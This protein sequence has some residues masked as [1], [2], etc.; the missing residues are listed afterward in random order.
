TASLIL[1][2]QNVDLAGGAPLSTP[3]EAEGGCVPAGAPMLK[4][5]M[6]VKQGFQRRLECT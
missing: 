6:R 5:V 1:P 4:S 2:D 3:G